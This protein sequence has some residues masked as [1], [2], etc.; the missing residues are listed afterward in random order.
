MRRAWIIGAAFLVCVIIGGI[1]VFE[2][3][4][5]VIGPGPA[6]P[7]SKAARRWRFD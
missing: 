6:S 2:T 1:I 3:M 7:P 4:Q 5:T